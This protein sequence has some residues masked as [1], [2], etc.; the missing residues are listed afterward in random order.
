MDETSY[1]DIWEKSCREKVASTKAL[2][3]SMAGVFEKQGETSLA[4]VVWTSMRTEV[5]QSYRAWSIAQTMQGLVVHY[6]NFCFYLEC[7]AIEGSWADPKAVWL[8]SEKNHSNLHDDNR[9]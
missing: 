8:M 2:N 3:Q 6:R 9:N 5:G 1:A 4:E 7:A